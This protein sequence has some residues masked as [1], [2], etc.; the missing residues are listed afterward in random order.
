MAAQDGYGGDLQILIYGSV[1][2]T[3]D[4][5]W[6]DAGDSEIFAT[7]DA[8]KSE[9]CAAAKTKYTLTVDSVTGT[10]GSTMGYTGSFEFANATDGTDITGT[11]AFQATPY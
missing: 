10:V 8:G 2:G 11:F 9:N 4:T 5:C 6:T 7:D 3:Y 1:A